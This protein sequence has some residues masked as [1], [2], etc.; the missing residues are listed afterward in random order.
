MSPPAHPPPLYRVVL[1]ASERERLRR[2]RVWAV[3]CGGQILDD[4]LRTARTV[5]Y[6]LGY[7]P[8]E[9]GDHHYTLHH[10]DLDVK[11]ATYLM[12]NVDYAVSERHR[13]VYVRR[14]LFVTSYPHGQPPADERE[15]PSS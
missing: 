14:F 12:F 3:A 5:Q 10:L 4:F 1:L 9:W 7:E 11:F 6:R 8:L 13:I 2:W 15:T